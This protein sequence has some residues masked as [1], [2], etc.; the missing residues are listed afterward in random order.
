MGETETAVL[1]LD[2][3]EVYIPDD[4]LRLVDPERVAEM[5]ISMRDTGQLQAIK[6]K[7]RDP[8]GYAVVIGAHRHSA[9]MAAGLP[10][11]LATI[12]DGTADECRLQEID[13]NLFRSELTPYDQ[14]TF[15]AERRA[16]FERLNGAV[17]PGRRAKAGNSNDPSLNR[18]LS[19]FDDLL[20]KFG[21]P[22]HLVQRA[23]KRRHGINPE[24]WDRLRGHPATKVAGELDKLARLKEVDQRRVVRLMTQDVQPAKS[25]TAALAALSDAPVESIDDRQLRVLVGAWNKAGAKARAAFRQFL[26]AKQS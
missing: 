12:F 22:K 25:V 19:F 24:V 2:P 26:T 20:A 3:A 8:R 21:L 7:P 17:K 10:F 1:R 18:Q 13:E 4:R 9:V 14:A 11:V 16:I 15:L 23:L 6:V 5:A